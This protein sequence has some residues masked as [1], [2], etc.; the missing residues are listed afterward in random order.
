MAYRK[1]GSSFRSGASSRKLITVLSVILALGAVSIRPMRAQVTVGAIVGTITD[2]TGAAVPSAAVTISNT[3][4]A[5]S[6]RAESD[7]AGNFEIL[8]LLPGNYTVTAEHAGFQRAVVNGVLLRVNQTARYDLQLKVGEV[9]QQI[10]VSASGIAKLQTDDANLGQVLE[11]REIMDLPLNGRNFLQ[12]LT[13]GAGAVP[14]SNDM[15]TPII[16]DTGRTGLSYSVSGQQVTSISYLVDGVEDKTNFD[17][18]AAS[19]P[20]L[21]AI[22]EFKI[23]RSAFSAEFGGAPVVINIATKSGTNRLHGTAFEYVRNNIFDASQ[24]QDPVVNGQRQIAPFRQNQFGGSMGGPVV[25]PRIYNGKNRTFWFFDYEGMR[26]RLFSEFIGY[27]PPTAQLNGD[28][29]NLRDASGKVI[30]I[31][32]PATYNPTTGLRQQFPGNIIPTSRFSVLGKK[33]ADLL[34]PPQ[35]QP[36]NITQNDTFAGRN[37]IENDNQYIGRIDH[38]ISDKT[39]IFGRISTYSAP[40]ILPGG[41]SVTETA[42]EPLDNKNAVFSVTHTFS[43]TS[44]NELHLGFNQETWNYTPYNPGGQNIDSLLGIKNLSP[45]PAQ[46]GAP[47]FSGVSWGYGPQ[48]WDVISSGQLFQYRDMLTLIRGRHTIKVG[49]EIR[50]QRP[51]KLAEDGAKRGQFSFTGDFTAQLQNGSSVPNTGA[52]VAD[53]LLGY[54]QS[55][56]GQTGSTYTKFTAQKYHVFVL[57][58]IKVNRDLTLSLGFRYEYNMQYKP[59]DNDIEG[60]CTTCYQYGQRGMLVQTKLG[61]VR[62]QVVDPDW[63]QFGPRVGFAWRPFGAKN[64]VFR[65]AYGIFYDNT[66][67]DEINMVEFPTDKTAY[68]TYQNQNPIPT[69]TLDQAFPLVPPGVNFSPFTTI[70]TDKWPKVHQWNLNLQHTFAANWM[71]EIGYVGSHGKNLSFRYNI[72]QAVLDANPLNPTPIQSRRPFPLY[73]DL[74]DS[75]HP[76]FAISN[77]DGL[78]VRLE[79]TFSHGFV[80]LAGYTFSRC[81]NLYNSSSTDVYNQDAQNPQQDYGLCGFQVKNRFNATGIWQIP[82]GLQGFM[83]VLTKGWQ[84]NAML[85][86]QSGS[87]I[88]GP[89]MPGDWANVG[90]RYHERMNRVCDGNLSGGQQSVMEWFNT[91]CFVPPARGTFGNAGSAI[92]IG[93]GFNSLD[94]SIFREFRLR[95]ETMLQFRWEAFNALNNGNYNAPNTSYGSA[96]YGVITSE[97][98]KREMQFS[99]RLSF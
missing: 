39:A 62:S 23:Q 27:Y 92:L 8:N 3:D 16:G 85:Q 30:P 77:Y 98:P 58:D 84:L 14:V 87:P 75:G 63:R 71:L 96:G 40:L 65:G 68:S 12:L 69:L 17:Q 33:F 97:G 93:P 6:R 41:I 37:R 32:D 35:V 89:Y 80:F 44:V 59:S 90:S 36:A 55:A 31:Y 29:S 94:A 46:Y 10:V 51:W 50:D 24:I 79:R 20:S 64:T 81:E 99:L 21:D 11:H 72:N 91:S 56:V 15:G 73:G 60:F 5:I 57:D 49:G 95:E 88:A 86:M 76:P 7:A 28:F 78:Q 70:P 9:A 2:A 53:M 4:T 18:M 13:V 45:L 47:S 43:A 1:T 25:L 83:G 34:P 38:R 48:T 42:I 74:L 26:Q 54:P 67:G 61:Q 52:D 19:L 82:S 66:K 22:E